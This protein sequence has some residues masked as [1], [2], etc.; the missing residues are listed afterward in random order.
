[1]AIFVR[2]EFRRRGVATAL[3]KAV[4]GGEAWKGYGAYGP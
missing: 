4:L 2:Q 3:V 1:M